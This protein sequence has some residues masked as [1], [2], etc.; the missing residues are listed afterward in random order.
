[1]DIVCQSENDDIGTLSGG[2]QQKV[3]VGRWLNRDSKLLILDEPFQGVDIRARRD[4]GNKIR[5]TA[6]GR[7][8]IVMACEIDEVLEIA[9]RIII[10]SDNAVAGDHY[11]NNLDKKLVIAQVAGQMNNATTN[12]ENAISE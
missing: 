9:D 8:T 11:N 4:I 1:M 3:M 6:K 10:L 5:E 12:L 2:N 7:A